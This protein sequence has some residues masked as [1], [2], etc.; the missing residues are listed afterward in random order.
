MT[1]RI[2]FQGE[3][4]AYSHQA[5][6][7]AR[8]QHDPLPCPTFEEAIDAVRDGRADWRCCR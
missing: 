8:P 4:A 6:R 1:A 7:Q 3:I 5:C 2:A